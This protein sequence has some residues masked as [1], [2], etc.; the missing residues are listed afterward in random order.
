MVEEAKNI[1][2]NIIQG[3]ITNLIGIGTKAEDFEQI[4]SGK[5][6]FT[7]LGIGNFGYTEKMKSKLNNKIYAV[8]KLPIKNKNF[9]KELFRETTN[10]LNSNNE[11]IVKLYGYFQGLEKIEKLKIIYEDSINRIN[12]ND[13]NDIKVYF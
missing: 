10:M 7:I 1:N 8:K 2:Q 13:K 6:D 9:F 12:F 4:S 5:L 3:N 11:Y